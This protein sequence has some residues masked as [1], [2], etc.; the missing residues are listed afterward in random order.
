MLFAGFSQTL[1]L[2]PVATRGEMVCIG[3][4]AV[5]LG[6]MK[7]VE[8]IESFHLLLT[9]PIFLL[10]LV[11]NV[12]GTHVRPRCSREDSSSTEGVRLD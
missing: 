1:G 11:S 4:N 7:L 6:I 2:L 8:E 12:C 5:A 10:P 9:T 3:Q